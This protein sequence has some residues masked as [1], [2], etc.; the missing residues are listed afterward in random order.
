MTYGPRMLR[1]LTLSKFCTRYQST[2]EDGRVG[3][4]SSGRFDRL[5]ARKKIECRPAFSLDSTYS[6]WPRSAP[7]FPIHL[8]ETAPKRVHGARNARCFSDSEPRGG[9]HRISRGCHE[10]RWFIRLITPVV[11]MPSIITDLDFTLPP[12]IRISVVSLAPC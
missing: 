7:V 1:K 3:G 11:T 8:L 2:I 10:P 5:T 4:Q 9:R 12:N 6:W